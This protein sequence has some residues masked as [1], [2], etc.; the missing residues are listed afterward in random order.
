MSRDTALRIALVAV[1][2]A[3]L[4]VIFHFLGNTANVEM[5]GR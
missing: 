3:L 2:A 1:I 5:F 4:V